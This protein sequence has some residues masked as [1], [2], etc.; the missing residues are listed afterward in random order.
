MLRRISRP[1]VSIDMAVHLLLLQLFARGAVILVEKSQILGCG[2]ELTQY[3]LDMAGR[4][5]S[6]LGYA[7]LFVVLLTLWLETRVTLRPW[8]KR[9][10]RLAGPLF[11]ASLLF[12][13]VLA[14]IWLTR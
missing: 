11:L 13:F 8:F 9:V 7:L 4:L 5:Q 1:D 3:A 2:N 12:P 14:T 6:W 10:L